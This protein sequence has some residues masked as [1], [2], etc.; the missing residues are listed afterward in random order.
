MATADMHL[1]LGDIKGESQDEKHKDEIDLLTFDWSVEN[2]GSMSRGGGGG[3]GKATFADIVFTHHVD[4]ASPALWKACAIGEHIK[5][6]TL[7]ASK[8]GKGPQDFLTMKLSDVIV[9]RV[10][11][12][13][14]GGKGNAEIVETVKMQA[15]NVEVEYKPQ[16]AD[17]SLD[18]GVQFKFNIKGDK[19]G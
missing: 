12:S 8:S 6:G 2:G 19:E 1:K 7:T 13:A 15:A 14:T 16:K 4:K 9:T 3:T 5:D 17:G 18:A 11:K 10:A